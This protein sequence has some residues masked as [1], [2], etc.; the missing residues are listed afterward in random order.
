MNLSSDSTLVG[1]DDPLDLDIFLV[2]ASPLEQ[3]SQNK[4]LLG[5]QEEQCVIVLSL[6]NRNSLLP[7]ETTDLKLDSP[8]SC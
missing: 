4:P 3:L 5:T 7:S 1:D 8:I 6:A 2:V